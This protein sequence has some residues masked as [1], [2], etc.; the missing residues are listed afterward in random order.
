MNMRK[1]NERESPIYKCVWI[2]WELLVKE[3]VMIWNDSSTSS[4]QIYRQFAK[5]HMQRNSLWCYT[6]YSRYLI[7]SQVKSFNP[8]TYEMLSEVFVVDKVDSLSLL[9]HK[10]P[11]LIKHI[12][13]I[14]DAATHMPLWLA[15]SNVG[16]VSCHY[17]FVLVF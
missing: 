10:S 12:L 14:Q 16:T 15:L 9:S 17:A 1:W 6:F 8:K 4:I 7:K 11:L 13:H 3:E 2:D 5:T